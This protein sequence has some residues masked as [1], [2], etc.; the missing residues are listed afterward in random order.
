MIIIWSVK[1]WRSLNSLAR[2]LLSGRH[3]ACCVRRENFQRLQQDL[4]EKIVSSLEKRGP[5]PDG[6]EKRKTLSTKVRRRDTAS[7]QGD[8]LPEYFHLAITDDPST[9]L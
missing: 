6:L 9:Y 5:G 4:A 8:G 1:Y 3:H 7:S 2:I